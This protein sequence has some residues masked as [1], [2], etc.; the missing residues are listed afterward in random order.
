[1]RVWI[2]SEVNQ[3]RWTKKW[4]ALPLYMQELYLHRIFG[5]TIEIAFHLCVT[6]P[7]E[8]LCFIST[9]AQSK[10]KIQK[11][12]KC[13]FITSSG[14]ENKCEIP[15][16]ENLCVEIGI[17]V[18]KWLLFKMC[19]HLCGS[20]RPSLFGVLGKTANKNPC[21]VY[22]VHAHHQQ[23]QLTI[24]AHFGEHNMNLNLIWSAC[25]LHTA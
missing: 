21:T 15:K 5:N 19:M 23:K 24:Q 20:P 6:L 4:F 9:N 18:L 10:R 22:N 11:E 1:M 14:S 25:S 3:I 13:K 16:V 12:T 8:I 2:F 7:G 17:Y